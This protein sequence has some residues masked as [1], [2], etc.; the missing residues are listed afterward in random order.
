MNAP[1]GKDYNDCTLNIKGLNILWS[2]A[3]AITGKPS[4]SGGQNTQP[5]HCA[6]QQLATK[7]GS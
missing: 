1:L 5:S 7:M 2:V 6:S 3:S 4:P